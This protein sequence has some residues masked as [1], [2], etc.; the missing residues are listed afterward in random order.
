MAVHPVMWYNKSRK[1]YEEK[2]K[3]KKCS[4]CCKARIPVIIL[5]KMSSTEAGARGEEHDYRM[6][7]RNAYYTTRATA[8]CLAVDL[9]EHYR[10]FLAHTPKVSKKDKAMRIRS[11]CDG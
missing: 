2:E 6:E 4:V 9:L 10:A 8:R 1:Y 3:E 7:L 5:F 11:L